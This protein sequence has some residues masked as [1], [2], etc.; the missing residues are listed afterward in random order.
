MMRTCLNVASVCF[1]DRPPVQI[2]LYMECD[3]IGTLYIYIPIE[4]LCY[5]EG[6]PITDLRA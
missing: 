5:L 6:H 4:N 2:Q 3:I 1:A